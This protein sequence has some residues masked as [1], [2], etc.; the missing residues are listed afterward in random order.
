MSVLETS[1]LAAVLTLKDGADSPFFG[2]CVVKKFVTWLL[3][4]KI[5]NGISV[6]ENSSRMIE[7]G[8]CS[9]LACV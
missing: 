6:Q 9:R 8:Q 3:I 5:G 4:T 1:D 7:M 2:W